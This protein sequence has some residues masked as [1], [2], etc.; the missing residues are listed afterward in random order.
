MSE[1]LTFFWSTISSKIISTIFLSTFGSFRR[2]LRG[3]LADRSGVEAVVA[4]LRRLLLFES[5]GSFA[6]AL[7]W[8]FRALLLVFVVLF[9]IEEDDCGRVVGLVFGFCGTI[10]VGLEAMGRRVIVVVPAAADALVPTPPK[11]LLRSCLVFSNLRFIESSRGELWSL[12]GKTIKL[13]F[14]IQFKC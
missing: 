9:G 10:V 4:P 1:N 8:F 3:S 13:M 14:F 7:S 5:A 2:S 6:R 12:R 11:R